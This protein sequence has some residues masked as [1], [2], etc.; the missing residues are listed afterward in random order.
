MLLGS[1]AIGTVGVMGGIPAVLSKFAWSLVRL[2]IFSREA[3]CGPTQHIHFDPI[4]FSDHAP[5]RNSLANRFLGDWL[6][7]FDCDHEFEPDLLVRM[8]HVMT[9]LPDCGAL[10]ALYRFKAPPHSPVLY[11]FGE[12]EQLQPVASWTPA[13]VLAFEIGGSGGGSLLIRR[14]AL[15]AIWATGEQPF[16]RIGPFSEDLSLFLRLKRA[17]IK[18]Y[19]APQIEAGHL[20]AMPVTEEDALRCAGDLNVS[21]PFSVTAFSGT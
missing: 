15:D 10:T 12:G 7:M 2:L 14:S 16:D 17:K 9:A 6:L 4:D 13:E 3:L 20:R 19:A 1:K 18:A 5:A 8:L 21:E 11:T